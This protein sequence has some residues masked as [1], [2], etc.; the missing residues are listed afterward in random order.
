MRCSYWRS[1]KAGL[2]K[3]RLLADTRGDVVCCIYHA[4]K[5]VGES[6]SED[7]SSSESES[8]ESDSGVDDGAAKMVGAGGGGAKGRRR[9]HRHEHGHEHGDDCGDKAA[10]GRRRQS[11]NAYERMPKNSV[12]RDVKK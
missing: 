9:G 1:K 7:D 11:P 3:G 2:C 6:S 12:R 8:D 10:K 5:A 4:P